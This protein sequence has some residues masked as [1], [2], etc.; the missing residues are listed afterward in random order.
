M[1]QGKLFDFCAGAGVIYFLLDAAAAAVK[2]GFTNRRHHK[3]RV[4]EVATGNPHPLELLGT[5]PGTRGYERQLHAEWSHLR[6]HGEWFRAAPELTAWIHAELAQSRPRDG[7]A[8]LAAARQE[9]N[10]LIEA[11]RRRDIR[12]QLAARRQE[13]EA[14]RLKIWDICLAPR[15]HWIPVAEEMLEDH[16]RNTDK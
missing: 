3:N 13:L 11:S 1:T 2:I 4:K 12:T 8:A 15:P 16:R 9:L 7:R 14:L 6:M 10:E 5:I